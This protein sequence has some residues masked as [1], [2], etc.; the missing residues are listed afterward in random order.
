MLNLIRNQAF[1]SCLFFILFC[2][3]PIKLFADSPTPLSINYS[4][5]FIDHNFNNEIIDV[6][7]EKY[8][9]W[10]LASAGI[11]IEAFSNA[12][13]GYEYLQQ[14][15]KLI[16][17]AIITSIDFSKPSTS[18][19]LFVINLHSGEILFNSLVAHGRNSGQ[20]YAKHFSNQPASFES[21]LGFYI[22]MDTYIGNNGFSLKLKGCEKNFNNSVEERN[23][24]I[25]GASYV[26]KDFIRQNGFLGR[27]HGCPALPVDLNNQIINTIKNGTCLFIYHPTKKYLQQSSFINH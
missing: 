7:I 18:E 21:S 22:T 26:S 10:K 15:K 1:L 14:S 17:P 24:V 23:I 19:R 11:S 3:Q 2:N 9:V 13:K 20:Q 5:K 12:I 6:P 8:E 25:H 4:I 27:S 16:N